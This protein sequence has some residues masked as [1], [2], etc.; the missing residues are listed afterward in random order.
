MPEKAP[1]LLIMH[2]WSSISSCEVTVDCNDPHSPFDWSEALGWEVE[3]S[4]GAFIRRMVAAGHALP[5]DAITYRGALVWRSGAAL[6]RPDGSGS[7]LLFQLVPEAAGVNAQIRERS[8]VGH[9]QPGTHR[10]AP[11]S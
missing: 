10:S 9:H 6:R 3:P 11:A 8:G 4:D 1:G 5:E 2:R 7:T